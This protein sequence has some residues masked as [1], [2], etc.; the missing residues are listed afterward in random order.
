MSIANDVDVEALAAKCD[1]STGADIKSICTEAGMFAIREGRDTVEMGDFDK[2]VDKV[3]GGELLKAQE[4][5]VMF[6]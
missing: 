5:G 2:A 3:K 6:A 1:G 4:S